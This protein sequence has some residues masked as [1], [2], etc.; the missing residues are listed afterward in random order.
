M[1]TPTLLPNVFHPVLKWDTDHFRTELELVNVHTASVQNVR[2]TRLDVGDLNSNV[3]V[4]VGA[5]STLTAVSNNYNMSNVVIGESAATNISN[6]TKNVYIGY[7]AGGAVSNSDSN[8]IVGANTKGGG[9]SNIYIG[10]GAGIVGGTNNILIGV[11][12]SGTAGASNVFRIANLAYGDIA[13]N[14]LRFAGDTTVSNSAGS[15]QLGVNVTE[16]VHTLHVEGDI[17]GNDGYG[18]LT[19]D[20]SGNPSADTISN[21]GVLHYAPYTLG[22]SFMRADH[23]FYSSAANLTAAGTTSN[24]AVKVGTTQFQIMNA[25][26]TDYWTGSVFCSNIASN[27]VVYAGSS[28]TLT[29]AA[30]TGVIAIGGLVATTVYKYSMSHLPFL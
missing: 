18:K 29:A 15:A 27:T 23:G 8:V 2:S 17:Y 21:F 1:T 19:M 28:N 4:G 24:F 12:T 16:P 13:L 14:T 7:G 11:N 3:Y 6:S 5:G 20:V 9:D 30:G 10:T 25:A 26:G 22:R